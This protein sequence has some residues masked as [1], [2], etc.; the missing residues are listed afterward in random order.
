VP[1]QWPWLEARLDVIHVFRLSMLPFARP[2]LAESR[3]HVPRRHLDLDDIESDTHRRLAELYRLNGNA[4]LAGQE[5]L[6]A[7]RYEALEDEVLRHFDRVYVCSA[8]DGARLRLRSSREVCILPNAVR[9]PA[10]GRPRPRS[11]PFNF[12]FVGT[13][14]YYPNEDGIRSF[15]LDV[16]PLIRQLAPR[17]FSVTVVGT[18][19]TDRIRQLAH[20]PH[21]RL[22]GPVPDVAPC[23]R[24]ADAVV[25]PVRAGG[26]TRIKV[27]EAFGHRRPVVST[28]IGVEG[29]AARDEEHLLLADT[30][31]AF[32]RQ[33]ERLM[34]NTAL[35]ERLTENALA[36]VRRSYSL[37]AVTKI[38]AAFP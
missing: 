2:Y 26:G 30:A 20:A 23:Y 1:A 33:C 13:L 10:S 31:E 14:G 4:A 11:G 22:V 7:E 35:A 25:V 28:S 36:L 32:A 29:I 38:V 21:V 24:D 6:E 27:I 12:L 16:V 3:G 19:A 17:D 9:L 37:E 5:E 18:G 8:D 34:T 15:C